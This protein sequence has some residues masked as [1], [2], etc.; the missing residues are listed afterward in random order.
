MYLLK[1]KRRENGELV[2][3]GY[4][5]SPDFDR[6][7]VFGRCGDFSDYSIHNNRVK[8]TND[9]LRQFICLLNKNDNFV[10]ECNESDIIS[11]VGSEVLTL[12]L[13]RD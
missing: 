6:Y 9:S 5:L 12:E 13:Y 11:A 1:I 10:A 7:I 2:T 8:V 4:I 3:S